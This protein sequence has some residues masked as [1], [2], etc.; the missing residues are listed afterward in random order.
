MEASKSEVE[1]AKAFSDTFG[2]VGRPPG[3]PG[4][5]WCP[6]PL[7]HSADDDGT[8]ED[9]GSHGEPEETDNYEEEDP[10]MALF[11]DGLSTALSENRGDETRVGVKRLCR[12]FIRARAADGY[13]K[14][15]SV[16]ECKLILDECKKVI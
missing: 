16:A 2:L 8:G 3:D 11:I 10:V 6:K 5:A 9:E 1:A 7:L 15:S 13:A 12:D 14:A 4:F